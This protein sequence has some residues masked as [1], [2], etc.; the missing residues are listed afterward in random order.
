MRSTDMYIARFPSGDGQT[1][2]VWLTCALPPTDN[3]EIADRKALAAAFALATAYITNTMSYGEAL[4][5]SL[6]GSE[7]EAR[8]LQE[9]AEYAKKAEFI[10]DRGVRFTEEHR[11]VLATVFPEF[12]HS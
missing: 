1:S 3:E 4:P 11:A 9:I 6:G 8:T 12:R 5:V 10:G 7:G 2:P